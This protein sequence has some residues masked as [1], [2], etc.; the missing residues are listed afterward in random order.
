M[1]HSSYQR[2]IKKKTISW[3][4][5]INLILLI[6]LAVTLIFSVIYWIVEWHNNNN[7]LCDN[8]ID[9]MYLFEGFYI[10]NPDDF[11]MDDY[12]KSLYKSWMYPKCLI[13]SAYSYHK[14]FTYEMFSG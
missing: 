4:Y 9:I 12:Y 14:T 7:T 2:K 10:R 5:Y 6:G 8:R 13:D 1:Y 11:N 3:Q